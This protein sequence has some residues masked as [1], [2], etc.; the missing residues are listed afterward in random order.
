MTQL[1]GSLLY[2]RAQGD[3]IKQLSSTRMSLP[4]SLYFY[5]T[6]EDTLAHADHMD[7][8]VEEEHILFE[9]LVVLFAKQGVN[10]EC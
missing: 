2:N 8:D 7:L 6:I 5:A 1:T 10:Y 3:N 9:E 4:E